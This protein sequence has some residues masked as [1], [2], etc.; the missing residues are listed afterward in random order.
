M[1]LVPAT[2]PTAADL[3][4]FGQGKLPADA[5][6]AVARHVE[7]CDACRQAVD[8][9][10]ADSFAG[11][12][13]GAHAKGATALP[14]AAS[15]LGASD[16]LM[17]RATTPAPPHG[18]PP[19]LA[20]HPRFRVVRE[21]GRGGMG[22]VYQAEHTMMQRPVAIKVISKSV[23]D[24]PEA[25]ARFEG[26]VRAAAKLKHPNIV[27]AYDAERAGDLHM[28]VMEYVEGVDLAKVLKRKGPLPILN[29]CHY[30][31]QAALGLKHAHEE[32]MVHRDV[33]PQNLMLTPK[34]QVKVLDF[35]LA[36]LAS[37][38]KGAGLTQDGAFM[39]TP[40]YVSPEQ[41]TDART[42]D[43]RAD[44]YSL[45]CTLYALL[46]GRPPFAGEATPMKQVLAHIEKEAAPLSKVRPEVPA[47]LS[48]VVARMLA[49]DPAKRFQTPGEVAQA[50]TPFCSKAAPREAAPKRETRLGGD[51]G[52]AKASPFQE[53]V[54]EARPKTAE[55]RRPAPGNARRRLALVA[56]GLALPLLLAGIILVIKWTKGDG[57]STEVILK[58]G[59]DGANQ[60]AKPAVPAARADGKVVAY[61]HGFGQW[62]LEGDELVQANADADLSGLC[63]GD[64]AWQD[65]DL[66][67]DFRRVQ[68]DGV[69]ALAFRR[70]NVMNHYW[71]RLDWA[72]QKTTIGYKVD[73]KDED[74]LEKR[75][76][77]ADD[78][79]HTIAVKLRGLKL[80]CA[81]DNEVIH[82]SDQM[83]FRRGTLGIAAWP[84]MSMRFKNLKITDKEGRVLLAGV[85]DLDLA[86]PAAVRIEDEARA[87]TV[88][89]GKL[90]QDDLEIDLT[91]REGMNFTG[92]FWLENRTRGMRIEGRIDGI[93]NI[94][95]LPTSFLGSGAHLI[96]DNHLGKWQFA[97]LRGK[98][99]RGV[100]VGAANGLF[101][102]RRKE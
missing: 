25:L 41:A 78:E 61:P 52:L 32:G 67:F 34:G 101:T 53:M 85:G 72:A 20:D 28:L 40:E 90:A 33:K 56:A 93:G 96:P 37:E 38:R 82:S 46:A 87:G 98:E 43:I 70:E 1:P 63:F 22:V 23:L 76:W 44:I 8:A 47:E 4:A 77:A 21:L 6:D 71:V 91:A 74:P 14:A 45:G 83:I 30:V 100:L 13:K 95:Y 69:F 31:R 86:D 79:W 65:F 7:G 81:L 9:A 29:A 24:H 92:D 18:L 73:L 35:G 10:P 15:K 26:E 55:K 50:L 17:G 59:E 27:A 19:E 99:L 12:V 75:G 80:E 97:A 68:G 42:A 5:V 57:S 3:I 102:A 88:W 48:G 94:C 89:K 39:G 64:P 36:R 66:T 84:N 49:K 62:K 16:S 60:Q 54:Q 58:F 51:T 11:L 2:H